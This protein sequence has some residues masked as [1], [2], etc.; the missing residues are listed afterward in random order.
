MANTTNNLGLSLTPQDANKKFLNWR[1]GIDGPDNSAMVKLDKAWGDMKSMVDGAVAMAGGPNI[2]Q[3]V[4]DMTETD[5]VYVYLG[6]ETGYTAGNWY[7]HNGTAWVSGGVYQAAAVQTDKTLT[8]DGMAAD[9][10]VVGDAIKGIE[11]D[12]YLDLNDESMWV[13]GSIASASGANGT[14]G[15]AY[16]IRTAAIPGDVSKIKILNATDY[17]YLVFAY[18]SDTVFSPDTYVGWW[19][20]SEFSKSSPGSDWILTDTDLDAA[21]AAAKLLS[22]SVD[23]VYFRVEIRTRSNSGNIGPSACDAL[24]F[25]ASQKIQLDSTLTQEGMAADAKAVG[26]AIDTI[27]DSLIFDLNDKSA[28]VNGAIATNG[29][30]DST[31][32]IAYTIRTKAIPSSVKKIRIVDSTYH[33]AIFA[34]DSGSLFNSATFIG[35]WNGSNAYGTTVTWMDYA[36]NPVVDLDEAREAARALSPSV[37]PVYFRLEIRP[38]GSQTAIGPSACAALRFEADMK[39]GT[40][41]TMTISGAAADAKGVADYFNAANPFMTRR[42][43]TAS[44]HIDDIIEPGVYNIGSA[45]AAQPIGMYPGVDNPTDQNDLLGIPGLK[46]IAAQLFV[47]A[48]PSVIRQVYVYDPSAN[49]CS[50][51]IRS[52]SLINSVYVW[53]PWRS[54]TPVSTFLRDSSETNADNIMV[55][56]TYT[57][58]SGYPIKN[59]PSADNGVLIVF[60]SDLLAG[61]DTVGGSVQIFATDNA[62]YHRKRASAG[63]G[64]WVKDTPDAPAVHGIPTLSLKAPADDLPGMSKDYKITMEYNLFGQTGPCTVKWQGSSST[65]YAKKNYTITLDDAVEYTDGSAYPEFSSE[66]TY[67]VGS[68]VIYNG[69]LYECAVAISTPRAWAPAFWTLIAKVTYGVGEYVSY[70]GNIYQCN[71]AITQAEPWTAGHWTAVESFSPGRTT[72][73]NDYDTTVSYSVGTLAKYNGSLYRCTTSTSG[74]KLAPESWDASKWSEI[75]GSGMDAWELDR[76]TMNKYYDSISTGSIT[77]IDTASRW[78]MQKKYC[79]KANYIDPSHLRNVVLARLWGEIVASRGTRLG[80][81]HA[82]PAELLAAPNYGA[83]D[84]FPV[85]ITINGQPYGIYTMNIPKDAWQFNMDT[86]DTSKTQY[87]VSGEDNGSDACR[88]IAAMDLSGST[89]PDDFEVEV[90]TTGETDSD[91]L[92]SLNAAISAIV[93]A[94]ADWDTDANVTAK[95]DV[96]S[97]FDY[98]IFTLCI[99]NNDALARNILYGSYDG[100]KWFMSAYDLD[101]T[102]GF[103][104]YG[105]GMFSV[106]GNG[107]GERCNFVRAANM[108]RLAY[109]MVNNSKETLVQRYKQLRSGILSD[110]HVFEKL[111]ELGLFISDNAYRLDRSIWPDIQSTGVASIPQFMEFYRMHCA[112]LDQKIEEMVQS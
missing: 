38:A 39:V 42:L 59:L 6:S 102:F 9:A 23:P 47:F 26:D 14:S 37:D 32:G 28:W 7:Y 66:N 24:L 48:S 56:G 100:Q 36:T 67:D 72:I 22:P 106:S 60:A 1:L 57:T 2:A 43:L 45:F 68:K 27:K 20:G 61:T 77:M 111:C 103:N 87:V 73:I 19:T 90:K 75:T 31:S 55:P 17:K 91:V 11:R 86:E 79:L 13:N 84:G 33:Y 80:S 101:T 16:T 21:R 78:G 30:I 44:D 29:G 12:L 109:L 104:P 35:I 50:A 15:E 51:L 81:G 74:T 54:I 89:L 88:W 92:T 53:T 105:N 99:N 112:Y 4:A 64:E 34:Y 71:T 70:S 76:Y 25:E 94:G 98:F 82:A 18:T 58:A 10:K 97:V 5:K 83:I 96:D 69:K 108:N 8:V 41:D 52:R 93:N 95:L 40:D 65:R 85:L 63:W 49:N 62:T 3:T 110:A 107:V 46:P